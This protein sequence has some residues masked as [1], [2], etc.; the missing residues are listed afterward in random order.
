MTPRLYHALTAAWQQKC[1]RGYLQAG[2]VAATV[3]NVN[4]DPK[5]KPEPFTAFDF[6]P[7]ARPKPTPEE[8]EQGIIEM[9]ARM[10]IKPQPLNGAAH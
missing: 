2:I 6:A 10:G 9:F 5:R 4:R 3:A 8:E 1:N 7:I